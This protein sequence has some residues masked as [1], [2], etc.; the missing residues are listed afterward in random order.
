M[1]CDHTKDADL[2]DLWVRGDWKRLAPALRDVAKR[3]IRVSQ[4]DADGVDDVLSMVVVRA[5]ALAVPPDDPAGWAFAVARNYVRDVQKSWYEGLRRRDAR[6]TAIARTRSVD[7]PT[8]LSALDELVVREDRL[9]ICSVLN[10]VSGSM[11]DLLV[12]REMEGRSVPEIAAHLGVE[13]GAAKMR[14]SRA[15]EAFREEWARVVA[16][17][18]KRSTDFENEDGNEDDGDMPTIHYV[19]RRRR[20]KADTYVHSATFGGLRAST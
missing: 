18:R 13:I 12:W 19:R 1:R 2:A 7:M 6:L 16:E 17:K 11:R 14:I 20:R 5:H 9:F 10:R 8:P 4:W 3:A 15:R